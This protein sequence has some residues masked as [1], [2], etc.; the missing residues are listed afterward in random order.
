M[1]YSDLES[2][3]VVRE[4]VYV[5]SAEQRARVIECGREI[6]SLQKEVNVILNSLKRKVVDD[7]VVTEERVII[8]VD[9]SP[10]RRFLLRLFR[11]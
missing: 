2:E 4:I 1:S 6:A 7:G 8:V 10:F 5:L 11:R 3:L 9:R